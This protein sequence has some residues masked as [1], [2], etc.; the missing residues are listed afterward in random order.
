M[1]FKGIPDRKIANSE[2]RKARCLERA[3]YRGRKGWGWVEG[4][5]TPKDGIGEIIEDYPTYI[6]TYPIQITATTTHYI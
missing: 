3:D 4:M 2:C 1:R 5:K 6:N